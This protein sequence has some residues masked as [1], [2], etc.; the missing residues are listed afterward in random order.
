MAN[1]PS[2]AF[3]TVCDVGTIRIPGRT[4]YDSEHQT[5]TITGSGNNIWSTEDEFQFAARKASGDFIL[6]VQGEFIGEG[7]NLHRKWGIMFRQGLEGDAV[8][9]DANGAHVTDG[10]KS[11]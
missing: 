10:L 5:Y 3:E 8:Y 11:P 2:G 1:N 7:K 4:F 6:T 9:A